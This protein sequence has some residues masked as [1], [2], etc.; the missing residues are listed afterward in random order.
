V[1][2]KRDPG[3]HCSPLLLTN[4]RPLP[5]LLTAACAL[6]ARR[7]V[8]PD[9]EPPNYPCRMAS[10]ASGVEDELAAWDLPVCR[11]ARPWV[12]S[13]RW[14]GSR[15][16]KR[17]SMIYWPLLEP[18]VDIARGRVR[19]CDCGQR[20][21]F[22]SSEQ[23]GYQAQASATVAALRP[24]GM[25]LPELNCRGASTVCRKSSLERLAYSA[26]VPTGSHRSSLLVL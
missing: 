18:R 4:G 24:P 9:R 20:C 8:L 16:L 3:A 6:C 7:Q 23:Y 14:A 26:C 13:G 22:G 11:R 15:S 19:A 10:D 17:R 2:S 21:D 5:L 25:P 12:L 1:Y